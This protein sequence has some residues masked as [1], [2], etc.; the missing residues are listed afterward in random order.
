MTTYIVIHRNQWVDHYAYDQPAPH[1]YFVYIGD[2]PRCNRPT[3]LPRA[4]VET[5]GDAR[6]IADELAAEAGAAGEEVVMRE[7]LGLGRA[8]AP[9]TAAEFQAQREALGLSA[10][11]MAEKLGVKSRIIQYW[12]SGAR[13]FS[14]RVANE[15]GLIAWEAERLAVKLA[16]PLRPP[17]EPGEEPELVVELPR[18]DQ[19]GWPARWWRA[20]GMRVQELVPGVR[21]TH[22]GD[23][24]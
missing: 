13:P 23:A 16:L 12:E 3:C 15:V 17:Y 2:D 22:G 24:G 14:E 9:T 5:L 8:K 1:A 10:A 20:V 19:G 21:L 18:G 7:D 11:E 4:K 6:S